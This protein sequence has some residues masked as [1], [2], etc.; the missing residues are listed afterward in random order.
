M[1]P[2]DYKPYKERLLAL[3]ARLH[4]DVTQMAS[5]ALRR[6]R[7]EAELSTMPVHMAELGSDNY[8]QEFSI[9][10]LQRESS[11]LRKVENALERIEQGIYDECEMCGAKIPKKR[12][13]AIPYATMCVKCAEKHAD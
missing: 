2:D 10:L 1:T 11:T 8:E 13:Q 9:S 7:S 3:R 12:L 6:N 5:T 4:G